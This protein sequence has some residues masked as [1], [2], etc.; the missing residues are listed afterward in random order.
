MQGCA[1]STL[2]H[3]DTMKRSLR[4]F[5]IICLGLNAIVGSGIF[6]LP[7]DIYREMG[8]LSPLAFVICA[9][10]LLPVALCYA[11]AARNHD[12]TGGPYL[13][14]GAA[15]G[16]HVGFMVGWMSYVNG[17]FS[18]AAVPAAAAAYLSRLVPSLSGPVTLKLV[19]VLTIVAFSALN[20]RGARPGAWTVD[21]FTIAKFA[22]LL[23][24]IAALLPDAATVPLDT[25]LPKG[26][27]GIGAG[28]FI[29]LFAVQGFE[30]VGVP[31]GEAE[32]PQ[33]DVPIAVVGALLSASA[34]YVVV[35]AT[36]VGA[37]DR[38]ADVSDAPLADAAVAVV[39]ALGVVIAIGGLISSWGFVSGTAL[40]T[41][42]YL[43]AAAADAH[44]PIGLAGVHTRFQS[45]HRSIIA[46]AAVAIVLT[47]L[48][49][50]RA[51]IGMSNV[52]VAV[53]YL[54]TCLAVA[55]MQRSDQR[56]GYQMLGGPTLPVLGA[57][58][59][60]WIFTEATGEEL[61]WAAGSLVVGYAAV[62]ITRMSRR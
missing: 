46:T 2:D 13:Y 58:V 18:F 24:L 49:D 14:A 10:G 62:A 23:L 35:Q 45:P 30:V 15:F 25:A 42:R 38:L 48:L 21:A 60:C 16:S 12:R 50:Y 59:S 52:T 5:D 22:V 17:L 28:V 6:L 9:A 4:L 36:L 55:R 39:P 33:R 41:P 3:G 37:F 32:R 11:V 26:I 1:T 34:L 61:V 44:F 47:T 56:D 20:Y 57:L 53:Q 51:L 43:F 7:D 8:G 19:A 31:A 40:G 54:A 27:G 29:A